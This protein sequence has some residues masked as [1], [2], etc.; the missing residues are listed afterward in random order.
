[1]EF[2]EVKGNRIKN[3]PDITTA[4]YVFETLECC[5]ETLYFNQLNQSNWAKT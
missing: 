5:A 3:L 1:V 2:P 4:I